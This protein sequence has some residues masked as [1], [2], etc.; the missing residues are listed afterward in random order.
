M[1]ATETKKH[2]VTLQKLLGAKGG[3]LLNRL[4][5]FPVNSESFEY[6]Y[7]CGVADCYNVSVQDL[8]R[9]IGKKK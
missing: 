8:I 5:K 6:G 4:D 2:I 1:I 7:L 3:A 9:G